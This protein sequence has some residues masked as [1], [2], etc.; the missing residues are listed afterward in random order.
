MDLRQRPEKD[1]L[2]E[3]IAVEEDRSEAERFAGVPLESQCTLHG[4]LRDGAF[5]HEKLT[6]AR[7]GGHHM[8]S[9][10]SDDRRQ[11]SDR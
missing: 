5:R 7:H 9:R 8:S 11:R 1:V 2:S 10:H 3:Q 4:E 6:D